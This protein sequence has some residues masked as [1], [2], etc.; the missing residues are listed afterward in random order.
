MNETPPT[1]AATEFLGKRT[2]VCLGLALLVALFAVLVLAWRDNGRRTALETT[3]ELTAVGDWHFYPLPANPP[4]PPYSAVASFRGQPL[5]PADYEP[6]EFPADD[7]TRLGVDEKGGYIIY[8]GPPKER[9]AA[10]DAKLGPT[11]FIKISPKAY[12]KTHP[13]Q[14]NDERRS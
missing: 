13:G 12:L 3:V 11:Y 7:M 2:A 14:S 6:H 10:D 8:K 4:R 1:E 9:D 5:Y